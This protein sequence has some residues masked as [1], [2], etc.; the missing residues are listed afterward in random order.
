MEFLK[1]TISNPAKFIKNSIGFV[2]CVAILVYAWFQLMHGMS[3]EVQTE[4][5]RYSELYESIDGTAFIF[6]D[7]TVINNTAGGSAVTLV[8]DSQRVHRGQKIANVYSNEDYVLLQDEINRLER[9]LEVFDKSAVESDFFVNDI[10]RTNKDIND[11]LDELYQSVANNDLSS[12][13]SASDD[14]LVK[15]NKRNLIVNSEKSYTENLA[16]L[17][18]QKNAL[19]EKISR[20]ST[21]VYANSSGFYFATVDGYESYFDIKNIDNITLSEIERL[22]NLNADESKVKMSVGKIVNDFVWYTVMMVD[23]KDI[24]NVEEGD[25]VKVE[26]PEDADTQITMLLEKIISETSSKKA[27]LVLRS[28]VVSPTFRYIRS[29]PAKVLLQKSQGLTI[30]TEAL[31]VIDGVKGVYVL[32]GDVVGFRRVEILDEKDGYYIVSNNK[33]DYIYPENENDDAMISH[34]ALS[35]YDNVIVSGKDLFDGKIIA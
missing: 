35:L 5:A 10:S 3:S 2:L 28:N 13:L 27:L 12:A 29:Q 1:P 18:M 26:F 34:K 31:R 20:V 21:P 11:S 4:P 32:V 23:F 30:P 9:K 8:S 16:S 7:E 19:N 15:L 17:N 33:N 25:Y 6:R 14:F 24:K 22:S